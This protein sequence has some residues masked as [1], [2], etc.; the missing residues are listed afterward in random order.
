VT[1]VYIYGPPAV[2]K[3]TVAEQLA[4]LT[5]YALFPNHLTFNAVAAVVP[6]SSQSFEP[7]LNRVRLLLLAEAISG[8]KDVIFTNN[9]AWG[10][11][12]ARGRFAAFVA[13]TRETV[14]GAGG[15][16]LFVHLHASLEVLESRV[17]C[18]SRESHGKFRDVGALR[19]L[20]EGY[21]EGP[22]EDDHLSVDT[23]SA[24]PADVARLILAR[25][26]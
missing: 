9:S 1:L 4:A 6:P 3:L 10:G 7:T 11:V 16:T 14:Q 2:G 22:L 12:D 25:C 15:R 13:A 19:R 17:V 5:G 8:G 18:E 20:L 23:S 26:L 24:P 21:E